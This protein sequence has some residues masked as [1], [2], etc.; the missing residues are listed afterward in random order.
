MN[1]ICAGH[2]ASNRSIDLEI[3]ITFTIPQKDSHGCFFFR[4]K[5]YFCF[6]LY[7]FLIILH[8]NYW[9]NI[10]FSKNITKT[11]NFDDFIPIFVK[12]QDEKL[13]LFNTK[14]GCERNSSQ[15][16]LESKFFSSNARKGMSNVRYWVDSLRPKSKFTNTTNFLILVKFEIW[17]SLWDGESIYFCCNSVSESH[18]GRIGSESTILTNINITWHIRCKYLSH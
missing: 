13:N 16:S 10:Y 12:F 4:F 15:V 5:L 3:C 17:S 18:S 14:Q 1:S 7:M 8:L 11:H 9:K 6:H 2:V